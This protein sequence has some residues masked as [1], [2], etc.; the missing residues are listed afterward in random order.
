MY[1]LSKIFDQH[2]L[3][4]T[5]KDP[6]CT[7]NHNIN[8]TLSNLLSHSDLVFVY[9]TY[10]FTQIVDK[11]NATQVVKKPVSR[12]QTTSRKRTTSE[13]C[14]TSGQKSCNMPQSTN[15]QVETTTKNSRHSTRAVSEIGRTIGHTPTVNKVCA[16]VSS[17]HM[18]ESD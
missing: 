18:I 1:L 8:D 3:I 14:K 17:C 5:L 16:T 9:T 2:S 15:K 7:F 10:G 4:Y 13:H 11:T 6:W 12:K